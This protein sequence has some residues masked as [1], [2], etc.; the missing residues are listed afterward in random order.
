MHKQDILQD[1][2]G[3]QKGTEYVKG[4][5][6]L[7]TPEEFDYQ[8]NFLKVRWDEQEHSIHPTRTLFL[9][10]VC[11]NEAD[12]IKLSMLASVHMKD[13]LANSLHN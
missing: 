12:V 9:S 4:L 8:I 13:G 5:A 6:D 3:R 7:L 11:Q 2:F 10:V 1:I